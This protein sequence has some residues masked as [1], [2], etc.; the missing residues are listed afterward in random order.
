MHAAGEPVQDLLAKLQGQ[1]KDRMLRA[2]APKS[3]G[4]LASA[5]RKFA[6]FAQHVESRV[7]F[8]MSAVTGDRG[9]AIH[10]EWTLVLFV[11][12]LLKAISEKCRCARR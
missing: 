3:K 6:R 9:A 10:N 11:E 5:I 7:L 4:T 1:A 8:Q 2:Y 12:W